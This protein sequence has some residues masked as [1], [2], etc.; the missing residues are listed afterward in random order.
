MRL[1]TMELVREVRTLHTVLGIQVS[2]V[3]TWL[4]SLARE[5]IVHTCSLLTC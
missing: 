5:Y 1:V 2:G 3:E 4:D